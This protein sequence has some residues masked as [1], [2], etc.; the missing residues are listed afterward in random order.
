MMLSLPRNSSV[1]WLTS[2]DVQATALLGR[3]TEAWQNI[4]EWQ[5]QPLL[6][7]WSNLSDG[8]F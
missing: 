3:L 6:S 7:V 8:R 1:F 2:R 4:A 5:K